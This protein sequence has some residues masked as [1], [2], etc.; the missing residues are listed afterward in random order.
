M[1]GRKKNYLINNEND[2][3]CLN[4]MK[5]NQLSL[6]QAHVISSNTFPVRNRYKIMLGQVNVE[7]GEARLYFSTIKP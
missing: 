2:R 5:I 7:T 4:E 3:I 6:Q 1:T